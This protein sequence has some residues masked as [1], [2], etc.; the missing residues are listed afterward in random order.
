MQ[1]LTAALYQMAASQNPQEANALVMDEIF[2]AADTFI[3]N[4]GK[5]AGMNFNTQGNISAYQNAINQDPLEHSQVGQMLGSLVY[6][7]TYY[8]LATGQS[9]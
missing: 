4:V 8:T 1:Q 9:F 3:E 7:L 6:D 5:E 2:Q